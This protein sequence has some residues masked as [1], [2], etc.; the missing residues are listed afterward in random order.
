MEEKVTTEEPP[1]PT[2]VDAI[3]SKTPGINAVFPASAERYLGKPC[4][5]ESCEKRAIAISYQVVSLPYAEN[6]RFAV[7]A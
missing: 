5:M 3:D 6:E 4:A 1:A 2:V 7:D